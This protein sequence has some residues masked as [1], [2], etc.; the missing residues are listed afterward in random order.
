MPIDVPVHSATCVSRLQ[1]EDAIVIG[2]S[3]M[4]ELAYGA[5]TDNPHF[6]RVRHPL[7]P[8]RLAG[9]S[10]GGS[11]VAVA[12]G[13]ADVGLGTDTAGSVRM[14]AA[15]CGLSGY[16]PSFGLVPVEGVLPLAWTLDHIGTLT[17]S[18]ADQALLVEVMA[19]LTSGALASAV[20]TPDAIRAVAPSNYFLEHLDPEVR[21]LYGAALELLRQ[22]GVQLAHAQVEEMALAPTLQYFTLCA[23]AAQVHGDRALLHPEGVGEEVLLRLESGRFVRAVDYVKAQRLR[24][25][26][27]DALNACLGAAGSDVLITPT[28]I[29]RAPL[30]G[31]SVEVGGATLPIHPALTRCTLPFNLTGM[32]AIS[33]PCGTTRSGLPVG[34]QLAAARGNDARLLAIA[35]CVE[36]LLHTAAGVR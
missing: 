8:E 22:Q 18:A 5:T 25:V 11:A 36:R 17:R 3:T 31:T 23:E 12:C 1:Q 33:V 16:K 7:A 19:G 26:L 30:P 4:H 9:G 13:I 20:P 6:G 14:P 2:M 32:P 15:L 34:L 10:S 28:V 29:V 27:H 21:D 35:T 24:S